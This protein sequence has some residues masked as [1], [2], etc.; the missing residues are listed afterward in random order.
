MR[1]YIKK[2]INLLVIVYLAILA[3]ILQRLYIEVMVYQRIWVQVILCLLPFLVYQ[4][5]TPKP[6]EV[7]LLLLI[8]FELHLL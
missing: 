6:H 4:R 2:D 7:L 5:R 1:N 8:L 3:F